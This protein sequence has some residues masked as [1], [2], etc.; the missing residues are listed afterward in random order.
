[1]TDRYIA[2]TVILDK[3]LRDD[4]AGPIMDAI[5]MIKH[6]REVKPLIAE[7]NDYWAIGMARSSLV[8]KILKVLQE[9]E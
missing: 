4:D 2:F 8:E 1:M 5:K 9:S 6:V 3:D 7:A